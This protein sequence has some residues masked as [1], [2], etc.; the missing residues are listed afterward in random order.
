MFKRGSLYT[1]EQIWKTSQPGKPYPRGGNWFT[2]YDR[3][4]NELFVFMNIGVP[5][6]TG[7]NYFNHYDE[8][9][10]TLVWFSKEGTRSL[11][12]LI[13]D[14]LS[15]ILTPHF[16]CRWDA[17]NTSFTYLGTG[18]VITFHDEPETSKSKSICRFVISIDDLHDVIEPISREFKSSNQAESEIGKSSFRLEQ[19]LEDFLV[20]NWSLTPLAKQY[21]I[22]EQNGVTV[23]RQFRTDTG[24]I[25]ILAQRRDK[26]D[27]L[28]VEL[29]RNLASD[30]AIGQTS[31]YMGWVKE[32]LCNKNQNVEGCIIAQK[33]DPKLEYA[34]KGIGSKIKFMRY[35]IDFRL[36]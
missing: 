30:V 13:Q 7:H 23:G 25:D 27:F 14:L 12:P 29:K 24:P 8:S 1:R 11:N 31:R 15:G 16:F 4:N 22:F 20:T 5:G 34:I 18:S 33:K 32:N 26:S 28:V 10:G 9:T 21:E 3:I 35:E 2:G 36:T 6:K 19:H 17:E